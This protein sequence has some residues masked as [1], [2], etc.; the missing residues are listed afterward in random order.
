MFLRVIQQFLVNGGLSQHNFFL[1]IIFRR[2]RLDMEKGFGGGA[3]CS[4]VVAQDADPSGIADLLDIFPDAFAAD[5]GVVFEEVVDFVLEGV[6]LG[7]PGGRIALG[8]GIFFEGPADGF[9]V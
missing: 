6:E 1:T 4:Q 3:L 8:E 5:A 7:M 2:G 9:D